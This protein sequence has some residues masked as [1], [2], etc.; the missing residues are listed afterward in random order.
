[1]LIIATEFHMIPLGAIASIQR[2]NDGEDK[3]RIDLVNG[4][5]IC[6]N[7]EYSLVRILIASELRV[8][9]DRSVRFIDLK[10]SSYP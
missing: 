5:S 4:D 6:C 3:T 1:M 8:A 9:S 2:D 7:V 10:N